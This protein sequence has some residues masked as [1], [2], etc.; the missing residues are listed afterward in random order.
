MFDSLK[1][2]QRILLVLSEEKEKGKSK[3]TSKEVAHLLR[4]GYDW[5]LSAKEVSNILNP[6]KG[7]KIKVW[8]ETGAVTFEI[9]REGIAEINSLL[10]KPKEMPNAASKLPEKIIERL[11]SSFKNELRELAVSMDAK[12]PIC[13]AILLRRI[14]E[15]TLILVF[16][17]RGLQNKISSA[18]NQF[19]SLSALLNLAQSTKIDSLVVLNSKNAR[20]I[21]GIKFLGDTAAHNPLYLPSMDE[22]QTQLP[23]YSVALEEIARHL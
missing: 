3:L 2:Y 20:N 19:M 16:L 7:R 13:S 11:G 9:T 21:E 18:Q 8:N 1:P 23:F 4:S 14:L 12:C 22:I 5:P 17:K 15:K 10:D 6:L